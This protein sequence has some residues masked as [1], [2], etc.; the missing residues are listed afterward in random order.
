VQRDNAGKVI[1]C[2]GEVFGILPLIEFSVLTS[3]TVHIR[4]APTCLS[5]TSS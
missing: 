4:G 5:T 1:V 2:V 3:A